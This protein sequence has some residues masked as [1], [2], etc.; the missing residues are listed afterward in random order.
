MTVC[1]GY[2]QNYYHHPLALLEAVKYNH[3]ECVELLVNANYPTHDDIL[4]YSLENQNLPDSRYSRME[5]LSNFKLLLNAG[6][7]VQTDAYYTLM[8]NA[9]KYGLTESLELLIQPGIRL[10]IISV[11]CIEFNKWIVTFVSGYAL[12]QVKVSTYLLGADDNITSSKPG[13]PQCFKFLFSLDYPEF[14]VI[15]DLTHEKAEWY[16]VLREPKYCI[17]ISGPIIPRNYL[18]RIL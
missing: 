12:S 15:K 7:R 4:Y 1:S 18:L 2:Y 13:Q 16:Q 17:D 14:A 11:V 10:P 9:V 5:H 6:C 3:L 8:Y